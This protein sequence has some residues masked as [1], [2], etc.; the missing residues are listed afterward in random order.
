MRQGENPVTDTGSQQRAA[1]P[2]MSDVDQD[3]L[4][5]EE[6]RV[7]RRE[8]IR[9]ARAAER[10][11]AKRKARELEAQKRAAEAPKPQPQ[12]KPEKAA[13]QQPQGVEVAPMADT[14]T[15]QRRHWGLV[16]SFVI[17]VVLPLLISAAYLWIKA[18]DQYASTVGFTVRA[19]NGTGAS[20]ILGGLAAQVSGGSG[21]SDTD[22]LYEF[23]RS[24]NLVAEIDAEHDLRSIYSQNWPSD[25]IFALRK[26]ASI[27]DLT[28]F[29]QRMVRISYNQSSHLIELQVLAFDADTAQT[30]A[31][32][33][34][35]NSQSLI[36]KLNEQA[37]ED[38]IRY[39]ESDLAEAQARIRGARTALIEFRTRTQLVDP[40]T[41][42]QGRMGVVNT[43]QQQLAE[44]LV[45]LD[46]L[47]DGTSTRDPRVVQANLRIQV[48]RQRIA[49]ER[50]NVANGPNAKT[51][52][53]Y[54]T[55]LA[56][57]EGLM[58]D[59]EFAEETY[60]AAL[61]ALDVARAEATRQ[62]R[63]LAAYVRPTLPSTAEFPQRWTLFG[64]TALFLL[65]AWSILALV[66]Y[67]IRDSR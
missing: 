23:I 27:E 41:D 49:E 11:E 12:P 39:A 34:L 46:L 4:S 52:Q 30:I 48:I 44:A 64:L 16:F 38:T 19:E 36:N 17:V 67:S 31:Q 26:D 25:P 61:T 9:A 63:Y 58:A 40:E 28:E 7:L 37:R 50:Q 5:K 60:R 13:P 29:W 35:Q 10:Q 3:S 15:M 33:I 59:R 8:R 1:D 21:Q 56:E 55:L 32:A 42:L 2:D 24:Q 66:Y 57:Y 54:P 6:F 65:L 18:E 20:S 45:E 51:G 22:I 43:L 14:A 47:Q 62:T 53:D